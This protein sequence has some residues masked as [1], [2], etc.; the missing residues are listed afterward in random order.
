MMK[1]AR[2]MKRWWGRS[3]YASWY[4]TWIV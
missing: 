4:A 1:F 3:S 2:Y